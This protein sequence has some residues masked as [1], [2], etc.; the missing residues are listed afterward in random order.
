MPRSTAI[1]DP[2]TPS[3]HPRRARATTTE[4]DQSMHPALSLE[5]CAGIYKGGLERAQFWTDRS[6]SSDTDRLMWNRDSRGPG[7][8]VARARRV[9][10]Q[11]L[12][13][14]D[15]PSRHRGASRA[16]ARRSDETGRAP[17]R[18]LPSRSSATPRMRRLPPCG[19]ANLSH[20]PMSSAGCRSCC[21][22]AS[23]S[24]ALAYV[25]REEPCAGTAVGCPL[26][27]QAR[28]IARAL[29]GG[30]RTPSISNNTVDHLAGLGI[31]R[32]SLPGLAGAARTRHRS[33]PV[34]DLRL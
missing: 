4:G 26:E 15:S 6:G 2:A 28:I 27:E 16:G 22:P 1:W 32:R 30:G 18:V 24:D 21:R 12:H 19:S 9:S 20:P 23:G 8:E 34:R 13:E 14:L 29:V 5:A 7:A 11:F 25:I 33:R 10:P 31:R 3:S 17:A